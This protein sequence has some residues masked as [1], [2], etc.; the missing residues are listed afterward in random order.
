MKLL[1]GIFDEEFIE[2]ED[3]YVL[4]YG[5]KGKANSWLPYGKKT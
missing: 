5:R 2:Q 3:R 1:D 4:W